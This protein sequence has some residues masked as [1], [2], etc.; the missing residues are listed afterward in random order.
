[1]KMPKRE[2]EQQVN[3]Q[4][5]GLPSQTNQGLDHSNCIALAYQNAPYLHFPI[6]RDLQMLP[7]L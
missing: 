7:E 5:L 4:E 6:Y 2:Q 1:M 3:D